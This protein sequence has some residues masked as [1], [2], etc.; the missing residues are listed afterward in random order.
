MSPTYEARYFDRWILYYVDT[1]SSLLSGSD[2][3]WDCL[4]R[5][6]G[7]RIKAHSRDPQEQ[8]EK[9]LGIAH[10]LSLLAIYNMLMSGN[11]WHQRIVQGMFIC[12]IL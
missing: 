9:T 6:L 11:L 10:Q 2:R 7:F 1:I 8:A 4:Q 12:A 3:L 5:P